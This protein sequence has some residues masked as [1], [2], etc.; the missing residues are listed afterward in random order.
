MAKSIIHNKQD[1]T[2]YLCMLQNNDYARRTTQEHHAIFG[3]SGRNLSEKWGLKVYLCLQHHTAGPMAVH[4]N[5]EQARLLQRKAQ[6]T[7]EEKYSHQMWM[8]IFGRNYL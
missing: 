2:C 6:E 4:N 7:F 3:N 1:G 8:Q 5:Q